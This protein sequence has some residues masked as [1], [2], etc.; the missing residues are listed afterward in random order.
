[1]FLS[2]LILDPRS[3]QV[4]REVAEPYEMHRT[5]LCAFPGPLDAER[6]LFRLES[7]RDTPNLAVLVQSHLQPDWSHLQSLPS[8]LLEAAQLKEFNPSFRERQRLRFRLRANPTNKR[9]GKRLGLVTEEAQ[10]HWLERKAQTHG[11]RILGVQVVREGMFL[12]RKKDGGQRHK[13]THLSVR[14][15]GLLE[16]ADPDHLIAALR[17]GIGSGKAFG[18]GLLSLARQS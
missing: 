5:L 12:G 3:R 6:V 18:F 10:R 15:D 4:R 9:E 11:F 1:M 14:Y 8:Y 7:M 13:L 17:N 2:R 16:V